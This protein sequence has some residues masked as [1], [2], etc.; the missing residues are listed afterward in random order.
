MQKNHHQH[1]TRPAVSICIACTQTLHILVHTTIQ[2]KQQ[3]T[4][5]YIHVDTGLYKVIFTFTMLKA[6]QGSGHGENEISI[7][8]TSA[9]KSGVTC[10]K[11]CRKTCSELNMRVWEAT[12]SWPSGCFGQA[13]HEPSF[14]HM[15]GQFILVQNHKYSYFGQDGHELSFMLFSSQSILFHKLIHSYIFLSASPHLSHNQIY[16]CSTQ[17]P[18]LLS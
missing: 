12:L 6:G 8:L 2:A 5:L 7:H 4:F 16:I 17:H 10:W 15:S 14:M 9:H 13:S 3:I 11:I 18:M 1:K